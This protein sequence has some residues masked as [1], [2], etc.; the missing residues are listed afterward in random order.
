MNQHYINNQLIP[1]SPKGDFIISYHPSYDGL[2]IAT[3]G[4]G[5][6]YKFL[7]VIGDKILDAIEGKLDPDLQKLWAWPENPLVETDKDGKEKPAV[8][9][10]EDGSRS[11]VKGLILAEELA[12][13]QP[14]RL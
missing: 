9:W 2:F 7:P 6:G 4:S 10:T 5:H 1:H 11:G 13:K 12:R 8:V 14:S 3:G